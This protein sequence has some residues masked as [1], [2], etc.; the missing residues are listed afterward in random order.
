MKTLAE[1]FH[2][3]CST[4]TNRAWLDGMNDGGIM[5]L[6]A[7]QGTPVVGIFGPTDPRPFGPLGV[8]SRAIY[9]ERD[10]SPCSQR[11]CV[12]GRTRCLEP[13]ETQDVLDAALEIA[14]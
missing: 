12:W 13:I 3:S 10:C 6:A 1:D 11:H 4:D 7:T 9:R 8:T 2:S 5:H 14:R